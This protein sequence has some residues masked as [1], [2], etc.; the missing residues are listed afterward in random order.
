MFDLEGPPDPVSFVSES[1]EEG[2]ASLPAAKGNAT[3]GISD[4]SRVVLLN[5]RHAEPGLKRLGHCSKSGVWGLGPGDRGPT[6]QTRFTCVGEGTFGLGFV[7]L[8][9]P[10]DSNSLVTYSQKY[11]GFTGLQNAWKEESTVSAPQCETRS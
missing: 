2:G 1:I 11:Q 8:C 3:G 6:P 4:L 7:C 9:F 10:F 5:S